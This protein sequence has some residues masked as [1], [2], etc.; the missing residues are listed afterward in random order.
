MTTTTT[1]QRR[2]HL[3]RAGFN[4]GQYTWRDQSAA[5][6]GV[7]QVSANYQSDEYDVTSLHA[8]VHAGEI[9]SVALELLTDDELAAFRTSVQA[10][11]DV[12]VLDHD[13]DIRELGGASDWVAGHVYRDGEH[14]I[15]DVQHKDPIEQPSGSLFVLNPDGSVNTYDNF[16]EEDGERWTP[17]SGFREEL[18]KE[19]MSASR[20]GSLGDHL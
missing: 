3:G 14:L 18:F 16:S 17:M 4:R 15:I 7:L 10:V 9:E 20:D 12:W 1:A 8:R 6:E 13:L 2:G 11:N 19:L 5:V